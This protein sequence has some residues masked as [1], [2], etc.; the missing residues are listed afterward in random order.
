[1]RQTDAPTCENLLSDF[2]R[3]YRIARF[4]TIVKAGTVS[5]YNGILGAPLPK[6]IAM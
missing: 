4:C 1:M 6:T 3:Q 2:A 5:F